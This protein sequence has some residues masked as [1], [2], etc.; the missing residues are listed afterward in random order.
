MRWFWGQYL[1]R[2]EDGRNPL[3][4]PLRAD[5]RGL[6]PAFVLT[7]E[8]D[9]LRDEGEAYAARLRAAGVTR[10]ARRYDGQIHGFFQM[11]GV[12]DR[13]KQAIDDAAAALR[14]ALGARHDRPASERG[15]GRPPLDR[16][17]YARYAREHPGDPARGRKLFFDPKGAGLRPMPSGARRGR[18]HRAGSLRRRRQ[19]RASP[20][21]RIGA[22]PLAPDRRGLPADGRRHHRRAGLLGD[23]QGRVGRGADARRR[24]GAPACR[25]QVG[26]RRTCV[27]DH[28]S[29][30]P[31]G[32]AAGLSQRDFADLIAYLEGLRIRRAGDTRQR[33]H[34]TDLTAA[35]LLQRAGRGRDHRRD[36]HGRR[37]PTAASSSASRPG[38]LRVVKGGTLLPEPFLTV[39]V[40]SH[41][42]RGLIGVALDPHFAD[43]GHVYVCYVTPRPYVHHRISRFTAQG[44]R[45][46]AR[47][48]ARPLR[49]GRPDQARRQ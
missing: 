36:G 13:G 33:H 4:S 19:V 24:R 41:W 46:H 18:R 32:L 20:P 7:A 23:R 15:R 5:L 2:P 12:M 1:A 6:P 49:R 27:S 43:N 44:R 35:R 47:Q 31:D 9:P 10:E 11:G 26:D 14:K 16:K 37:P 17:A 40:D 45:R 29:L 21:D 42:E 25:P 3:A 48:R 34:R 22:R 39:E 38:A 30:M 8:F 28:T